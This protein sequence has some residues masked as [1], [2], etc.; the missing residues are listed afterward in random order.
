[1]HQILFVTDRDQKDHKHRRR[2]VVTLAINC[3]KKLTLLYSV[4]ILVL[5]RLCR[6]KKKSGTFFSS[7]WNWFYWLACQ[8]WWMEK[9]YIFRRGFNLV[10]RFSLSLSLSRS[11]KRV[12]ENPG[13]EVAVASSI[14][15]GVGDGEGK[16]SLFSIFFQV[17]SYQIRPQLAG[18]SYKNPSLGVCLFSDKVFVSLWHNLSP[19]D[20]NNKVAIITILIIKK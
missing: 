1:M 14:I 7:P 20:A 3:L 11:V 16:R 5:T 19:R 12:G 4:F 15:S 13:N 17:C 2:L 9:R 6:G 8:K 10:P 18:L